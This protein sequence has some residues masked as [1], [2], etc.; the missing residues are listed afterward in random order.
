MLSQFDE[1]PIHQ[2]PEPISYN[3]SS[4][5]NVYERHWF[6]G[7]AMDG[8]YF[9]GMTLGVYANRGIID[10]AFSVLEQGGLQHCV[11]AS[12]RLPGDLANELGAGPVRLEIVEPMRRVRLRVEDNASGMA[13]DLV[14]STRSGAV[15]EPRQTL[16]SGTRRTMD[17]TRYDQF[18]RWQGWIRHPGGRIE[19]DESLC[20]GIKDRSWGLRRYGEP[21]PA[22]T[23]RL[24]P[25]VLPLDADLL[26]RS[27]EPCDR[28]R[29]ARRT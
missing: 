22:G 5:R 17:A 9:F 24:P 2:T 20:L 26:G 4:D 11:H 6:N 8:R 19:V 28:L 27:R 16:W 10:C 12:R 29:R 3:A 7:F 23:D 1:Y 14:F 15:R 25:P 18:G 21:E 13:C